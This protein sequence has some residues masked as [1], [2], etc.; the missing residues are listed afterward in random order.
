[1]H[2]ESLDRPPVKATGTAVR[3]AS[4]CHSFNA[5]DHK[6]PVLNNVDLTLKHGEL[7]ILTGPSGAG[8][9]TLL[10]LVGTLRTLQAGSI[11][12][13]GTE[14]LGL[15]GRKQ[16][17]LRRKI[18]FIFQD[19]NLFDALTVFQ[20]L[21]LATELADPRPSNSEVMDR[22]VE[23]LSALGMEDYLHRRPGQLSTGQKQRV[24]IARALINDPKLILAD[25]PTASLDLKASN[26]VID[27]I[28]A[29][30]KHSHASVLMVTHDHRIFGVA[31]RVVHM[32]DGQIAGQSFGFP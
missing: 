26:A 12:V 32:I 25:E 17:Q 10:T 22:A 18:G 29:R 24:A 15:S 28:K 19:H 30:I 16:R 13:L 4:V 31:D 1:M 9:T 5:G 2:D 14:L 6:V 20:T 3:I 7:V 21:K 11:E 23:V 27:L 8:K